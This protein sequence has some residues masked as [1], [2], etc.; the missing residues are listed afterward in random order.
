MSREELICLSIIIFGFVLFLVG[1]NYYNSYVG[2]TGVFLSVGGI[3][4]VVVL[5]VYRE[6]TKHKTQNEIQSA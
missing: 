6:L 2:W 1:A 5:Y 4:A 3:L